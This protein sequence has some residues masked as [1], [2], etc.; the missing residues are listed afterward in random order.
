[1]RPSQVGPENKGGHAGQCIDNINET[2]HGRNEGS[3][4]KVRRSAADEQAL[5]NK[6]TYSLA[7][8][9]ECVQWSRW[10]KWKEGNTQLSEST[11]HEQK[12]GTYALDHQRNGTVPQ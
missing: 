12:Q 1:M 9:T 6:G 4:K 2:A 3:N 8:Q 10:A 11:T 7:N 5:Q